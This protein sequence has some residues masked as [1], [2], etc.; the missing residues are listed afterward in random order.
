MLH[1]LSE[2][3]RPDHTLDTGEIVIH[4]SGTKVPLL[5]DHFL[6]RRRLLP[7]YFQE[8][9]PTWSQGVRTRSNQAPYQV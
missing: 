1:P 9:G 4:T 2:Y 3:L 6:H 7:P 5:L 8:Q